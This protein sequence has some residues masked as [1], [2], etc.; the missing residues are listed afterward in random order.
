MI[1]LAH[2]RLCIGLAYA[3]VTLAVMG[4]WTYCAR[5]EYGVEQHVVLLPNGGVSSSRFCSIVLLAEG[6]AMA[7][8]VRRRLLP[9]LARSLAAS[10]PDSAWAPLRRGLEH[11]EQGP[12]W[13][14]LF[15]SRQGWK[16]EHVPLLTCAY[17]L[18]AGSILGFMLACRWLV[19]VVY[20]TPSWVAH[21]AALALGVA[22]LGGNGDWHYCGYPY[23]FP[24]AFVFT[25]TLTALLA[26]RWWWFL[27]SFAA[28]AYSKETSILLV[29]AFVLLAPERR[30]WRFWGLLFV[31][32][33]VYAAVRGYLE[34]RYAAPELFT[35][36]WAFGRNL[37]YFSFV[38]FYSWSMPFFVIG[39]ARLLALQRVFPRPLTR[40]LVLAVPLLGMALC[41]GWLEEMRQYL[42]LLP[43]AGLLAF[44]WCMHEAGY[45]HLLR[46][47]DRVPA[48][49]SSAPR[50]QPLA[51]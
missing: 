18:I 13:L 29:A 50:P 6:K 42:E 8:F 27:L 49:V 32:M 10:V 16:A 25:L 23:D 11:A 12:A 35:G 14:R 22:L 51:A 19:H 31:Q 37:K 4:V 43:V 28:A 21:L 9:D 38:L 26:R 24:Q 5:T 1:R 7:P 34:L 41:K 20:E 39:A 2:C 45:G 15:L 33:A 40:L 3:V 17:L 46:A 30:S 47:R 48:E 44:H 36:F